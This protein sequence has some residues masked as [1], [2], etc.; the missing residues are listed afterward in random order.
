MLRPSSLRD[1][2][3]CITRP[4]GKQLLLGIGGIMRRETCKLSYA[5]AA[6]TLSVFAA[7]PVNAAIYNF[8]QDGYSGGGVITG[9]F[10]AIDTNGNGQIN[11]FDLEVTGFLLNFSGDF[12]VDDFT[13]YHSDLFGLVYDIGSGFIGDGTVPV[14]EGI[15]SFDSDFYYA[16][17]LG[18]FGF[19]GGEVWDASEEMVF[20][21]NLI[22]VTDPVTVPVPGAVWLSC[23]GL[24][25]YWQLRRRRAV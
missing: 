13:H 12:F 5:L 9:W 24:I 10:D 11:S 4:L 20:T 16:S 3:G 22:V 1:I 15:E 23:S 7:L 25:G 14:L 2:I 17:G 19:P 18:P 21:D 8:S 6:L